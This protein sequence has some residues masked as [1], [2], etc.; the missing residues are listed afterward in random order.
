MGIRK[1]YLSFTNSP[2]KKRDISGI[3]IAIEVVAIETIVCDDGSGSGGAA[4]FE[5]AWEE[6]EVGEAVEFF[7]C[8]K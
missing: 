6:Y 8:L 4:V 5:S 3:I 7:G 2:R 1:P